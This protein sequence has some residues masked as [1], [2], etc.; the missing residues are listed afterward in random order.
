M[1]I[2][3]VSPTMGDANLRVAIVTERGFADLWVCRVDSRG[4]AN[5][6][7]RW[8]ITPDRQMANTVVHFCSPGMA[9][10]TVCWVNAL[11]ESGWRVPDHP[12]RRRLR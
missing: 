5:T 2:I 10:L 7:A 6:A 12:L 4:M 1:A 8:F 3:Y 9:Q 11:G